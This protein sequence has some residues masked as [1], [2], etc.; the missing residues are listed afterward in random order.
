MTLELVLAL[1]FGGMAGF[2]ITSMYEMWT[3]TWW[4]AVILTSFGVLLLV[5]TIGRWKLR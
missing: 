3:L 1:I 5:M 2:I 4:V